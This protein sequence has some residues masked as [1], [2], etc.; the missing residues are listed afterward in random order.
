MPVFSSIH[1]IVSCSFQLVFRTLLNS[2]NDYVIE[3]DRT[4]S[5]INCCCI[6]RHHCATRTN[7]GKLLLPYQVERR[8]GIQFHVV[9]KASV[10]IGWFAS[11]IN[12]LI[13]SICQ[14]SRTLGTGV[15]M[16]RDVRLLLNS[17]SNFSSEIYLSITWFAGEKNLLHLSFPVYRLDAFFGSF[18]VW[19][20]SL[21]GRTDSRQTQAL[22]TA[23]VN[24]SF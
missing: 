8:A 23:A 3:I 22:R 20:A 21:T 9:A 10:I 18:C 11:Q 2:V 15:Q 6:E 13:R 4:A 7:P 19:C 16:K 14:S 17:L 12:K 24:C 1:T 5:W